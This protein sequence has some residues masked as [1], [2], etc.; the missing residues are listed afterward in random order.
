[1][2][3]P[4]ER[5]RKIT[6][7][8]VIPAPSGAGALMLHAE[9]GDCL[10]VLGVFRPTDKADLVAIV[11]FERCLQSVFGYP[12]DEAYRH[13]PRGPAGDRP[14]YGFFEILGSTWPGRL[15]AYN[16]HAFP[17]RTPPHYAAKRHYFIGCHD[18]SGEFL[19]DGIRIE[20][21]D[22]SYQ[23]AAHEAIQRIIGPITE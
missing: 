9:D 14:G 7:H 6:D 5:F 19:A 23:Q 8:G 15:I 10:V 1:V 12:N 16:R 4:P 21:T 3:Q 18:A 2:T 17:D 20:L 22:G 13:D 11:T